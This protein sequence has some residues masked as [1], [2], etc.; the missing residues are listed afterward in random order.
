[1]LA[2]YQ[3]NNHVSTNK[4]MLFFY[5]QIISVHVLSCIYVFLVAAMYA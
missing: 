4:R 3:I 2:F 5:H 1:M